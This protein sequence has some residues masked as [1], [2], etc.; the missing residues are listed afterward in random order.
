MHKSC[1][2]PSAGGCETRQEIDSYKTEHG[3]RRHPS[4]PNPGSR[5]N[6]HE[7]VIRRIPDVRPPTLYIIHLYSLD[8]PTARHRLSQKILCSSVELLINDLG[9]GICSKLEIKSYIIYP[10][11]TYGRDRVWGVM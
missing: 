11:L 3:Y 5:L 2:R 8:I 1:R 4:P 7:Y 10:D 9:T 6:A